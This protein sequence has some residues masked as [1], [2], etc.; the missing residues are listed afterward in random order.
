M[1]GISTTPRTEANGLPR[2]ASIDSETSPSSSTRKDSK[3]GATTHDIP[4]IIRA[5]G[6][7][8][9]V[10]EH[11]L[12]E[13]QAQSQQNAQLW[14]LADKQRAMI[15]GL[16]KDLER[17]LKD[18]EKY[19][20]KLKEL[21][22]DQGRPDASSMLNTPMRQILKADL[23]NG[24]LNGIA[25]S[26][27]I[28]SIGSISR[29]T[30]EDI[31]SSPS[32]VK[33][34][35]MQ[36]PVD[37]PMRDDLMTPPAD[38][39]TKSATSAVGEILKPMS[40]VPRSQ[41]HD[42]NNLTTEDEGYVADTTH[43]MA[44]VAKDVSI[45]FSLPPS[46]SL[47]SRPP[48]IPPPQL[49]DT[50]AKDDSVSPYSQAPAPP[51]RKPPLATY[52][53]L[54]SGSTSP[55]DDEVLESDS[56]YDSLLEVN[57]T[58][59]K[60]NR[61]RRRTREE[62]DRVRELLAIQEAEKRSLSKR[63][64]ETYSADGEPK[65]AS[66]P[67]TAPDPAPP[68]LMLSR[69]SLKPSNSPDK[70][71]DVDDE[72]VHNVVIVEKN[73][74]APLYSPGLPS[75]P[76][77]AGALSRTSTN[78]SYLSPRIGG[79]FGAAPL[80]PRPPRQPIPLPPNMT[81]QNASLGEN[82][83][84]SSPKPSTIMQ[85][86]SEAA[87][88][89]IP[90]SSS[91]QSANSHESLSERRHIFKGFV[92]E[93]FP[94][95]LLPPNALPSIEIKMASSR[96][97]PSRASLMSLTQLE[98]DPVFTLAIFSRA[99]GGELW[100]VEKNTASLA[101][102]DQRLKQCS[103]FTAKTPD[104]SLFSGHAPAKLDARRQALN[105]YLDEL[106]NTQLDNSTAIE[107]CRYLSTN[108]LPPNT[109]QTGSTSADM[110]KDEQVG[111]ASSGD[112]PVMSGY[113]T[114]RGKNFGGW[115]VRYFVLQGPHLKYYEA[116]GGAHLGTIKL[117]NAQIRKQSKGN[118]TASPLG[119]S[120]N[121]N[122]S[123]ELD[124]QYR[125]A[126]LILEPKKKDPTALTKH[127]LCAES[128]HE[129]G[130]WVDCL[131][132]FSDYREDEDEGVTIAPGTV[133]PDSLHTADDTTPSGVAAKKKKQSQSKKHLQKHQSSHKLS[134]S[135]SKDGLIGVSY[136]TTQAGETPHG[137]P[138]NRQ[139]RNS[140]DSDAPQPSQSPFAIS[141]PRDLQVITDSSGWGGRG[142]SSGGLVPPT[143]E[144]KKARK[145]SFFGFGTK[146]R[147]SS[148]GP[149][150]SLFGDSNSSSPAGS[151]FSNGG[152]GG[153][154][155]QVF[156]APLAEAVRYNAPVDVD[157]PLPA[158][159]YR[160]I[161]YLEAR[162]AVYEEG[163]FRLS[164][165]NVLIKQLRERFNNESDVNLVADTSYPDIH[166]V[167]SLL[168]MY[169]RE[170]PTT[171]LTR[172]LHMQFLSVTEM[173]DHD[174]KLSALA[175]LA[176]HLPRA[177]STLLKY[178]ISFLIRIINNSDRNKMTARNVGIVF[179]PTL[180]IPASVF[181]LLLQH[182][183]SVFG[184]KPEDYE[185]PTSVSDEPT[186][187]RRPS[188]SSMSTATT[189]DLPQRPSTSYTMG[190]SPHR[191][192]LSDATKNGIVNSSSRNTQT[193]PPAWAS[194]VAQLHSRSTPT[195]PLAQQLP[196][197]PLAKPQQRQ[198]RMT[199]YEPH[200]PSQQQ[201][202]SQMSQQPAYGGGFVLPAGYDVARAPLSKPE[203]DNAGNDRLLYERPIHG[204]LAAYERN[205]RR[206]SAILPT[207]PAITHEQ[208]QQG[209]GSCLGPGNRY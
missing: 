162:N 85:E 193:P 95:L 54:H 49:P 134:Q 63:N 115:K 202:S 50:V 36:S 6:S 206:E 175:E 58:T 145:R 44:N 88:L 68:S 154:A 124:D 94:D 59:E 123:D 77:P 53:D 102:L 155:R 66:K 62:D 167:A 40:P 141:A 160:C 15:L 25:A 198:Q 138:G 186:P 142:L 29:I 111:M 60:E 24:S 182:Y 203:L 38:R 82:S 180:N 57:E 11:L 185:L 183:E 135:N 116:P 31:L 84:L 176:T 209:A 140:Q 106:V 194:P 139:R 90:L 166:A 195:P 33:A 105:I 69:A 196:S 108:T 96:M 143:V 71:L 199:M 130:Q 170:L 76:S 156:G 61:G 149:S 181:A 1:V 112:R 97:K 13:K 172:D 174:E 46:R 150:D 169:L 3:N 129:R 89:G 87:S 99:D 81:L 207:N 159:V 187:T 8:E 163:I 152:T 200:H 120:T 2:N 23:T 117:Q 148:D 168:K 133:D 21:L 131:L 161:Q 7:A 113:L 93:E 86:S 5:A 144:E 55:V 137:A 126:F 28:S 190:D 136:E 173:A 79:N 37:V 34:P 107:L 48:Q 73:L 103:R 26:D 208:Q 197:S 122:A 64:Q 83:A 80:S 178:L 9:A 22:P 10:I 39:L 78:S 27:S 19:R 45:N 98:D 110:Q 32:S 47:P 42:S 4:S 177:N 191:Q 43:S 109:D 146:T 132:Q 171:I 151:A 51:P 91:T 35:S 67:S 188:L 147:T 72:I 14:R 12:K 101:R 41:D 18:K 184:I 17:A 65:S 158:V 121:N 127:F 92:T 119:G 70:A 179:S 125:H 52:R 192:N 100:R 20:K 16:N 205:A 157:V 118:D 164:G 74:S 30:T 114:K 153:P 201:S 104:R 128:D 189:V 165:S 75:S 56:D 204:G